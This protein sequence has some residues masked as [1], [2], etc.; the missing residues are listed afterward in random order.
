MKTLQIVLPVLSLII[1]SAGCKPNET[2]L[3]GQIFIVTQGAANVRLGDVEILLIE[4]RQVVEFLARRHLEIES[5]KTVRSQE[6]ATASELAMKAQQ[7]FDWFLANRPFTTNLDYVHTK[8]DYDLADLAHSRMLV[9]RS[10]QK[11]RVDELERKYGQARSVNSGS[12]YNRERRGESKALQDAKKGYAAK[13]NQEAADAYHTARNALE[14]TEEQIIRKR[15]ESER[16][17]NELDEI[18]RRAK[19]DATAKPDG[20]NS[21]RNQ[22]EGRLARWPS[23]ED[24]L[25]GFSPLVIRKARTDANGNFSLTYPSDVT[26]TLFVKA[27]RAVVSLENSAPEKYH[28]L[29][30]APSGA[31]SVRLNFSN[32]NLIDEDPDGYLR[33]R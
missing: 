11:A 12:G 1:A 18:E 27:Q 26:F 2:S 24:F 16:L 3:S 13:A 30:N 10:A 32:S 8:A 5:E 23:T 4:K 15:N 22:A 20:A 14:Q 19:A 21:R 17:R 6:V 9:T 25:N 31:R 28:W 33:L 29:I 7:D